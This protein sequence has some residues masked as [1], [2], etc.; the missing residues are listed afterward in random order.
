MKIF[1]NIV[2]ILFRNL[3]SNKFYKFYEKKLFLNIITSAQTL[4]EI[5]KSIEIT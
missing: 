3:I 2:N 4:E 1:A 5:M